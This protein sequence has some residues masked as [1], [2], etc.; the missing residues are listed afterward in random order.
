MSQS[1]HTLSFDGFSAKVAVFAFGL[2][3]S[4]IVTEDGLEF[5]MIEIGGSKELRQNDCSFPGCDDFT[6]TMND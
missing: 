4:I 5:S 6:L 3:R 2:E 1:T